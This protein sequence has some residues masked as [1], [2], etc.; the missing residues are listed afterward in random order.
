M[1]GVWELGA[2][3]AVEEERDGDLILED[4]MGTGLF[5]LVFLAGRGTVG[6]CH[7]LR[8][9]PCDRNAK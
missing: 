1:N 4:G 3:V 7:Q 9:S 5:S 6:D 2:K 8:C